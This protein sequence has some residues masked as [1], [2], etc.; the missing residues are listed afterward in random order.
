LKNVKEAIDSINRLTWPED[1]DGGTFWKLV[2]YKKS[3]MFSTHL[4][5][6]VKDCIFMVLDSGSEIT[7]VEE[8]TAQGIPVYDLSK[9]LFPVLSPVSSQMP[10]AGAE[11]DAE[12]LLLPLGCDET[13]KGSKPSEAIS[14]P[15]ES[16]SVSSVFTP[17]QRKEIEEIVQGIIA[18]NRQDLHPVYVQDSAGPDMGPDMDAA[19]EA[20]ADEVHSTE[21]KTRYYRQARTGK[22]RKAGKSKARPG[23]EETWLTPEQETSL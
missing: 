9:G 23:E 17:E 1:F 19:E 18:I 15:P 2:R 14:E 22:M 8:M 10:P 6:E 12:A 20:V 7:A 4:D 13:G 11:N 3:V 21:G 16:M 5:S